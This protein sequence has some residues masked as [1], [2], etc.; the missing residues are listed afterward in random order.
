MYVPNTDPD[1]SIQGGD[2]PTSLR[3]KLQYGDVGV[4]SGSSNINIVNTK[5][6]PVR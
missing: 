3:Y 5:K 6:D 2:G 4:I 1:F